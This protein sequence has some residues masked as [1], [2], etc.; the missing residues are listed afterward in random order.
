LTNVNDVKG[1]VNATWYGEPYASEFIAAT[2][3]TAMENAMFFN[4]NEDGSF[5]S[6]LAQACSEIALQYDCLD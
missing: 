2:G 4:D 3:M 5:G 1:I 6:V